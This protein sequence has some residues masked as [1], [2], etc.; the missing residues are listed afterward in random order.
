MAAL[1]NGKAPDEAR[2]LR[3]KAAPEHTFFIVIKAKEDSWISVVADGKTVTQGVLSQD[4]Q[5]LIKAGKEI[6]L[7]TGN[8]GGIE[9]SYNGR[10]LGSIGSESETRTLMFTPTG[11]AQ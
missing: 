4:R 9:V 1:A 10:P 8:A 2:A 7:K 11:P 5:K 6:I 3:K